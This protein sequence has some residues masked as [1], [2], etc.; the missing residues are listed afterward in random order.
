ME[1]KEFSAYD[2]LYCHLKRLTK[3][4]LFPQRTLKDKKRKVQI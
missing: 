1:K 4:K 3:H 2:F